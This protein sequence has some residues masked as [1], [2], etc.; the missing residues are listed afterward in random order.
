M[1]MFVELVLVIIAAVFIVVKLYPVVSGKTIGSTSKIEAQKKLAEAKEQL[2][3][4][5]LLLELAEIN[6]QIEKK[7]KEKE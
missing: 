3:E 4:E 6:K 7:R 2:S 1:V 5:E